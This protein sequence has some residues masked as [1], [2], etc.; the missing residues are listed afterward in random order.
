MTFEE[1]LQLAKAGDLEAAVQTLR[2]VTH[3]DLLHHKAWNALGVTYTKMKRYDDADECFEAA[4]RIKPDEAVYLKNRAINLKKKE[5]QLLVPESLKSPIPEG[6]KQ[7]H[8]TLVWVVGGAFIFIIIVG[9]AGLYVFGIGSGTQENPFSSALTPVLSS[10]LPVSGPSVSQYDLISNG[11]FEQLGHEQPDLALKTFEKA[12]QIDAGA[13]RAWTGK[14]FALIDIGQYESAIE[15][16]DV[17][18]KQ[19]PNNHNALIGRQIASEALG[20][21]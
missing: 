13:P 18:L 12:I 2:D 15:A 3:T 7:I 5:A 1:G 20:R 19:D 6:E 16:F 17:A 10:I 14:G 8:S 21:P 11:G 4:I 9:C